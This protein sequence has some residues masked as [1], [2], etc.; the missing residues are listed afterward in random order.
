MIQ[1]ENQ[2]TDLARIPKGLENTP[3]VVLWEVTRVA[4]HC[5]VDITRLNLKYD[6]TWKDQDTLWTSLKSCRAFKSKRLPPKS[7]PRAWLLGLQSNFESDGEAVIFT[8]TMH[9]TKSKVGPAMR[10]ELH[11]L[12]REQSSRLFRHFGSDR[13]LEV[14][15]PIVDS[16]QSGEKDVE[17]V[18]ARWLTRIPHHFM[19]RRW[20]GFYVRERSLKVESLDKQRPLESKAVFYDRVMLFAE[21]GRDL[22]RPG[23]P[24]MA[25]S[26]STFD[27]NIREACS[28][29]NMLNWLLNLDDNTSESYLKLFH[30]VALGKSPPMSCSSFTFRP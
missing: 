26:P 27:H 29:N 7:D 4:L 28:R 19:D 2:L 12:K 6:D 8:A 9:P 5:D 13:F 3:L 25:A 23:P 30:R 20:S 1:T 17:A 24:Q 16:W 15:I 10:L 11:P 18:A 22:S 14:R 21:E